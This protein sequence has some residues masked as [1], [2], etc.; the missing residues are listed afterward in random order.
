LSDSTQKTEVTA[1]DGGCLWYFKSLASYLITG[2]AGFIGSSL[3]HALLERGDQVRGIDNFSTGRRANLAAIEKKIDLREL[4]LKTPSAA[5][6]AACSGVD[7]IL[8]QAALPSVPRSVMDPTSS[9]QSNID[10]TLHLL[11]AARE[12][13][14]RDGRLQRIVY[15]ASSSAYGDTPTL[16]KQEAMLPLP[17]SP[18]AVTK[19][20]GELYMQSFHR[21]YGLPTVALRYFN[22]F[23]PRQDPTS[24]YSGVMA[25]FI[26]SMLKDESP[27]IYGDGEQSRDFTSIEDVIS[28]N[29]LACEAPAEKV[30]GR[31]FNIACGQRVT[32]NQTFQA[33]KRIIGFTG[34]AIHGPERTGDI[35]HSLADI[36]LAQELLGY[37]PRVSFEEGLRRTVEWYRQQVAAGAA[38]ISA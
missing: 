37:Q 19:L 29:L 12:A 28:A 9:N 14:Q 15:A 24:Q 26:T 38:T 4:D 17:I 27:T 1:E 18:Y 11:V 10:G 16:P 6:T 31:V 3:A 34:E 21:V 23:G 13:F 33:L 20:A 35:K 25:K 7:Y 8:H 22:V 30:A 36:S 2:I 5:L 32:L